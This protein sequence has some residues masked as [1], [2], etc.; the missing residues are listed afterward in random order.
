[1]RH[2]QARKLAA[3]AA[4]PVQVNI[5]NYGSASTFQQTIQ[6]NG[7]DI[8]IS[9][10]GP[11]Y[12]GGHALGRFQLPDSQLSAMEQLEQFITWC[13]VHPT[14]RGE[15]S[16]LVKIMSTLEDN[17][18]DVEGIAYIDATAWVYCGLHEADRMRRTAPQ[19]RG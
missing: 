17:G 2:Q 10:Y 5:H 3:A 8:N 14:W 19:R 1:M 13:L 6:A 18:Y 7:V 11:E 16:K 15:C 12:D 9:S 4:P